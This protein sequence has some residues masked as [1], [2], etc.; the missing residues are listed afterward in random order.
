MFDARFVLPVLL[1][2]FLSSSAQ[3]AELVISAAMSLKNALTEIGDGFAKSS[4]GNR[5]IFNF[6][7]SGQLR[8]QIENG[9]PVDVFI[10]ADMS[11]IEYL[12]QKSLLLPNTKSEFA[13][14]DL[15]VITASRNRFSA[16]TKL[17]N[18]AN[19]DIRRIAIGNPLTVPV[20]KYAKEA[21]VSAKLFESVRGK[22]I[23]AE[24]VRQVLDYVERGEVDAGFVFATDAKV[25]QKSA[26]AFV[27]DKKSHTPI[28]YGIGVTQK[29]KQPDLAKAF[30]A[31]AKNQGKSILVNYGFK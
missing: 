24:N 26:V 30:L 16:I 11:D 17:A 10:S 28:I 23:F 7:G 1:S 27:V 5:V 14:N 8:T 31:Y 18:L 29:S 12:E 2:I 3:A 13:S 4:T 15:V 9:A 6:A 25:A 21:L 20:G 22:L 19:S